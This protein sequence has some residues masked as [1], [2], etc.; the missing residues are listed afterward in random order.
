MNPYTALMGPGLIPGFG[1]TSLWIAPLVVLVFVLVFLWPQGGLMALWRRNRERSQRIAIEDALKHIYNETLIGQPASLSSVAGA[2]QKSIS[3]AADLLGAM[4]KR[5]MVSFQGGA[6][7]LTV[8]GR[9]Y[10]LHVIRAHRLWE[11]YLAEETGFKESEWHR[12]AEHFEHDLSPE[13][14]EA[15][16]V[17][18][19]HPSHD[20]HGDP[21]PTA[22]GKLDAAVGQ[23]LTTLEV[24][25]AGRIL[26]LEDEPP[27]IYAQLTALGLQPGLEVR[28]LE[29][30]PDHVRFWVNGDEHILATLL[31]NSVTVVPV[32]ALPMKSVPGIGWLSDLRLGGT[33]QVIELSPACRGADRRRLLDLGF[34]PGA[35][36]KAE[37]SSPTGDPMAY[38]IRG[39]LIALRRE[40]SCFIRV[41]TSDQAVAA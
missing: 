28:L 24:D 7:R 34:V 36:V 23:P 39:T 17:K 5:K 33:A 38:R 15:L 9:R 11:R 29:K 30:S 2:L 32:A 21:I 22:D 35:E 40:Q 12:R 16:S 20:P 18:L 41:S 13:E 25:S 37:L 19:N 27:S 4:E 3:T 10:A 8:E 1:V 6:L 14:V 26:H 31:A